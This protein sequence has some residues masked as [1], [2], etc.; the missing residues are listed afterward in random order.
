[1]WACPPHLQLRRRSYHG[2]GVI[3]K[4]VF[5]RPK[6]RQLLQAT[7]GEGA[8]REEHEF[9]LMQEGEGEIASRME[10]VEADQSP[11]LSRIKVFPRAQV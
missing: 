9:C 6:T 4:C 7:N 10:T 1:M 2:E 8:A 3:F 11:S 5:K